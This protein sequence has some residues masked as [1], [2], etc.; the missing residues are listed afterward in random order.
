MIPHFK[1]ASG[2][3]AIMSQLAETLIKVIGH[4]SKPALNSDKAKGK[5]RNLLGDR[6]LHS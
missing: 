5:Q 6:K 3:D 2:V 1:V 4:Q